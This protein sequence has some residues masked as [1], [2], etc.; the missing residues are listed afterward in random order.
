MYQ[1]VKQI[2]IKDQVDEASF[3]KKKK[4][5]KAQESNLVELHRKEDAVVDTYGTVINYIYQF[6][7]IT[8]ISEKHCVDIKTLFLV[9][10]LVDNEC[11]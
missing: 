10:F 4:M 7:F 1:T 11:V 8:K 3:L 9:C 5:E 2:C 6:A